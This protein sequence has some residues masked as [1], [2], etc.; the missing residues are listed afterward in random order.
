MPSEITKFVSPDHLDKDF[1]KRSL[2]NG[3]NV[4]GI[5]IVDFQI[6]LGSQPGDNYTSTIYRVNVIY[7]QPNSGNEEISLIVKSIPIDE[8][9]SSLE[10][11]GVVDKE[12]NVYIELLPKLS[13][14]LATTS[15]APKSVFFSWCKKQINLFFSFEKMFRCFQGASLQYCIRRYESFGIQSC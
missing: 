2:E 7:K 1:F 12:V 3:L 11:L 15:V 9:R 10:E 8:H 14:I 4:S 6:T 13:K 5:G